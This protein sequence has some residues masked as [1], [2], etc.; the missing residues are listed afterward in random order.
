ML[1]VVQVVEIMVPAELGVLVAVV[2]VVTHLIHTQVRLLSN[3][4]ELMQHFLLE[5]VAAEEQQML[6]LVVTAVPV[7]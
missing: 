2:L 5:V 3:N 4:K 7:S 6:L 1:A